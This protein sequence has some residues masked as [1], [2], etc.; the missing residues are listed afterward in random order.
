VLERKGKRLLTC[1]RFQVHREKLHQGRIS[2]QR[3]FPHRQSALKLGLR[4]VQ[5][6][7]TPSD[8]TAELPSPV[9]PGLTWSFPLCSISSSGR[10][11]T[12][13]IQDLRM[14]WEFIQ[15][16]S[17]MGR[18]QVENQ[19]AAHHASFQRCCVAH[20]HPDAALSPPFVT[21]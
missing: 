5:P 19:R 9:L 7:S 14:G 21:I 6:G 18:S 11:S 15:H 4:E 1:I 12:V 10:D 8:H 13:P 3:S 16:S 2:N 20:V 17:A